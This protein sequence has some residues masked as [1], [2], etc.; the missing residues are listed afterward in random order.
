VRSRWKDPRI[1]K[2]WKAVERRFP[3]TTLREFPMPDRGAYDECWIRVL[4]APTKPPGIVTAF[5][6]KVMWRLR[7]DE[8][9]PASVSGVS[10][11][12]T[13]KHYAHLLPAKP[14]VAKTKR[15]RVA[16]KRRR[17]ARAG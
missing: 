3:G 6:H 1:E 12:N 5:A 11:E 16:A 9:W 17:V 15:P 4:N 13:A 10:P 14:L 2:L 8:P 7:G